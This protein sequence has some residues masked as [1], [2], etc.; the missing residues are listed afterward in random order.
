MGDDMDKGV[1]LKPGSVFVLPA[2]HAHQIWT[3]DEEQKKVFS[4]TERFRQALQRYV[5]GSYVNVPDTSIADWATA[6]YGD[7]YP[8]LREVK[9]KYDPLEF[10]QYEQS[11]RPY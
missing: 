8:R 10:F 1:M 7:N 9:T 3:T 11:I 6:Y 4:W 5:T 2:N